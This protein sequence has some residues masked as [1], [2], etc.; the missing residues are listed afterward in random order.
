[1]SATL[2]EQ[3]TELRARVRRLET[4]SQDT[5][6]REGFSLAAVERQI[7][8]DE[9]GQVFLSGEGAKGILIVGLHGLTESERSR[10]VGALGGL[11]A[12]SN[13]ALLALDGVR[14]EIRRNAAGTCWVVDL[15]SPRRVP[16]FA[17]AAQ[18]Q[19]CGRST[20]LGGPRL[21]TTNGGAHW[22]GLVSATMPITPEESPKACAYAQEGMACL[23]EHGCT[24]MQLEARRNAERAEL[25]ARQSAARVVVFLASKA[26]GTTARMRG[27]WGD[28][29]EFGERLMSLAMCGA[30]QDA[31]VA[32]IR[33]EQAAAE[34]ARIMAELVA[35]ESAAKARIAAEQAATLKRA[36]L[37]AVLRAVGI[38]QSEWD[39]MSPK[40]QGLAQ[41]RARLAG[42]M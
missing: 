7:S 33:A 9:T 29:T 23:A 5:A 42:K 18:T 28:L 16:M 36:A 17:W 13:S 1:M 2:R 39:S 12:R 37:A 32:H 41:H 25:C 24:P 11:K 27:H 38:T 10:F 26:T 21:P 22:C 30:S 6:H 4:V 3:A 31:V 14:G 15:A 34:E 19:G 8:A 20:K 35:E 40:Q